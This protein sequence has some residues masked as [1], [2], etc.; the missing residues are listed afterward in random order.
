MWYYKYK[1]DIDASTVIISSS[2]LSM[3]LSETSS[4]DDFKSD[5]RNENKGFSNWNES[6]FLVGGSVYFA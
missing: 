1:F 4:C 2:R 3:C 6:L 5:P